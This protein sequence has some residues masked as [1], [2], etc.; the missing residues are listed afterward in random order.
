MS[1]ARL[2][3]LL[4]LAVVVAPACSSTASAPG[5]EGPAPPPADVFFVQV[6]NDNP[7]DF[8]IYFERAGTSLR[9]GLVSG[10][11]AVFQVGRTHFS[12]RGQLRLIARSVVGS[13][14]FESQPVLVELG[15][16]VVFRLSEQLALS[17]V[18]VR[19]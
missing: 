12:G 4:L 11:S 13:Q 17:R 10:R 19:R 7:M 15:E 16:S 14:A 1:R 8:D 18:T 2:A 9:L 3:L 6:Q 5:S